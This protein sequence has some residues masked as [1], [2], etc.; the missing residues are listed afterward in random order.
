MTACAITRKWLQDN[1]NEGDGRHFAGQALAPQQPLEACDHGAIQLAIYLPR[2]GPGTCTAHD[3]PPVS[4]YRI[5][6]TRVTAD[7]SLAKRSLLNNPP[8]KPIMDRANSKSNCIQEV[9]VRTFGLTSACFD[10]RVARSLTCSSL[11]VLVQWFIAHLIASVVWRT[12][13]CR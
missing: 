4:R 1:N 13:T 3:S 11:L 10:S 5:I 2:R 8:K 9:Q 12:L 6:I 7:I